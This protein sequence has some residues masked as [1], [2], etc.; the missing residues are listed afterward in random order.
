MY[1]N[2]SITINRGELNRYRQHWWPCQEQ[3]KKMSNTDSIIK[4]GGVNSR[5]TDNIGEQVTKKKPNKTT[6]EQKEH[7]QQLGRGR[8]QETQTTLVN[9]SRKQI[10][11]MNNMDPIKNWEERQHW[12]TSRTSF[13]ERPF[14]HFGSLTIFT[15]THFLD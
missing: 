3:T 10:K 9:K 1:N 5:D 4:W 8:T 14:I 2:I 15:Y 7:H 6:N 11:G 12:W 13:Q